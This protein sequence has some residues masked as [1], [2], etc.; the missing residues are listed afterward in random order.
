MKDIKFAT[1]VAM[2]VTAEQYHRD[3]E[4]PLL[5]M[6]YVYTDVFTPEVNMRDYHPYLINYYD[7]EFNIG[8]INELALEKKYLIED[9]NPQIFLALASMTEE[10]EDRVET[11]WMIRNRDNAMSNEGFGINPYVQPNYFRKATKEEIIKHFNK[12][13][14]DNKFKVGDKVSIPDLTVEYKT[15]CGDWFGGWSIEDGREIIEIKDN[16]ILFKD[17]LHLWFYAD[18]FEKKETSRFPFKLTEK[19]AKRII[20]LAC[21]RWKTILAKKWGKEILLKGHIEVSEHFYKEMRSCCTTYQD[22]LFDDIFGKDEECIP[23]G[24]PCL[25]RGIFSDYSLAYADGKGSFYLSGRKQGE[26]HKW[27]HYQ[28]LDINNLPV[29]E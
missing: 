17:D 25:V 15:N 20:T 3:L 24:T 7:G 5:G 29:N 1:K 2:K 12:K 8:F 27:K 9:Y 11:T 28:V 18:D 22:V 23:N 13:V 10:G 4:K 26:T 6:G 14:M 19:D 16:L 21:D